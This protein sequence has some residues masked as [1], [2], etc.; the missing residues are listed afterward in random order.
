MYTG[1]LSSQV[2]R[3]SFKMKQEQ[4]VVVSDKL[5]YAFCVYIYYN[6]NGPMIK[7]S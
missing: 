1:I 5:F 2:V 4:L 7:I 6:N 3:N